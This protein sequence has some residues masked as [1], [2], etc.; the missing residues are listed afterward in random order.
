M[1]Y[2]ALSI[3]LSTLSFNINKLNA[4]ELNVEEEIIER[5]IINRLYYALYNRIIDEIPELKAS[6][7]GDKHSQIESRL[8]KHIGNETT[9]R[10]YNSFRKLKEL[11]VWAD[12]K[13]TEDRPPFRLPFLLSETNT[14]IRY[15]K[16]FP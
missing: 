8:Q 14:I 2:K 12:Y 5:S 15:Q 13:P 6:T 10:V 1:E 9:R 4:T 3:G 11:R 7:S 16:I